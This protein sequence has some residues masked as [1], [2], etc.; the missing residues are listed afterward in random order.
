MYDILQNISILLLAG[1]LIYLLR[2]VRFILNELS[3][4]IKSNKQFCENLDKADDE[5]IKYIDS[6][7]NK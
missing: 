1:A 6:K 7:L 2:E 4:E 5:V 3:E